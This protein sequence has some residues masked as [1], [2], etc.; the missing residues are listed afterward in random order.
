MNQLF[1]IYG[2][3][4]VCM[5]EQ[6][7]TCEY[8]SFMWSVAFVRPIHFAQLHIRSIV[9]EPFYYIFRM[10]NVGPRLFIT[11]KHIASSNS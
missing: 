2:Y 9:P 7:K 10:I 4:C 8:L 6:N 5:E 3:L 1:G 11:D